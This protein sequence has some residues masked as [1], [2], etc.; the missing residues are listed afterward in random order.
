MRYALRL[1]QRAEDYGE[2]P[3]GAVIV[4]NN[5]CIAEGWNS[6]IATYDATAH[7]EIMAIRAAGQLLQN[8]R[9]PGCRLYV[10][11]EPC[12]MCMGAIVNARIE[13]L[14]FG[15]YD[16]N[17]GASGS[18]LNLADADF[19]NHR[20]AYTGGIMAQPCGDLLKTFFQR[21]RKAKKCLP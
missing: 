4:H 2:V 12:V 8:Y 7:A 14:I 6:P 5:R 10:T 13:H 11:L 19:L 16:P 18:V 20:L 17:R 3:I 1:A 21:R 15:A 9:L